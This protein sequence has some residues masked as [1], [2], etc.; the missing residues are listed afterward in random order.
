MQATKRDLLELFKDLKNEYETLA[1]CNGTE[2]KA[3][4]IR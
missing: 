3:S 4:L 1:L 2:K